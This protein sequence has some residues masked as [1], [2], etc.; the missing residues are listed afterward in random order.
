[1][2]HSP[3]EIDVIPGELAEFARAQAEGDRDDE[4][5]LESLGGVGR[6]VQTEVAPT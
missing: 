5:R 6:V 2:D 4:E 3:A 1:V